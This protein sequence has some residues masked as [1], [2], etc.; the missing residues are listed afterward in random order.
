MAAIPSTS[1]AQQGDF[2]VSKITLGA[3]DTLTYSANTGQYLVLDNPT[4]SPIVVT[5]D[6]A[7]ATN[8]PIVG[9][10]T[11]FDVSAGKAVTVAA[12]VTK[13]IK[14]DTISAY[15]SGAIAVTGGTGLVAYIITA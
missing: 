6:G 13:A 4:A 8:I 9:T 15:L 7:S 3:S 14:L 11:T 5:I 1:T 10:G 12:G 2:V